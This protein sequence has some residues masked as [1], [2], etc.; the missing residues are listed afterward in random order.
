MKTNH[1]PRPL[2]PVKKI[3]N[4]DIVNELLNDNDINLNS[5]SPEKKAILDIFLNNNC[6]KYI[7]KNNILHIST[8]NF[9]KV[10]Q[11]LDKLHEEYEALKLEINDLKEKN[12]QKDN[13]II[14]MSNKCK[15]LSR[16]GLMDSSGSF[17]LEKTLTES[18]LKEHNELLKQQINDT[19]EVIEKIK[20]KYLEDI[21]VLEN[22]FENINGGV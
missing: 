22:V 1:I 21:N 18:E 19:N 3:N 4:D 7:Q 9:F 14:L 10:F 5:I 20:A 8:I 13:E 6:F 15:K 2:P 16:Q 17:K 12:N 11:V